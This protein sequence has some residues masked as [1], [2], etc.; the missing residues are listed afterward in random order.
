MLL[1]HGTLALRPLSYGPIVIYY[2]ILYYTI[3]YYTI[4]YYTTLYYTILYYTTV[5]WV[6]RARLNLITRAMVSVRDWR[7]TVDFRNFIVFLLGRDPGTLKSNIVSKKHPQL[8]R[9][10][11]RLSN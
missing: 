2:T 8:I 4:L 5:P 1:L 10:D 9:S 11:L 3:L 7:N 6:L